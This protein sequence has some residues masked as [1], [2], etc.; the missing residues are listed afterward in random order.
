MP[1][2]CVAYVNG[3]RVGEHSG[4]FTPMEFDLTPALTAGNNRLALFVRDITAAVQG[5]RALHPLGIMQADRIRPVGG[6]Q[7]RVWLES[8]PSVH[9]TDVFVKTST[10]R[11][12]LDVDCELLN[13]SAAPAQLDLR[14]TVQEWRTGRPTT[15]NLPAQQIQLAPGERRTVSVATDWSPAR[16]WSPEH[17]ELHVLG[18][19]LAGEGAGDVYDQRFGFREFWIEGG[20]FVLNGTHAFL[21]FGWKDDWKEIYYSRHAPIYAPGHPVFAGLTS[22]DVRWWNATDGRVADDAFARP[23][24][25]GAIARGNWHPLLGASRRENLSLV[26][27]PVGRGLLMLCPAHIVRQGEHPEARLLLANLQRYLDREDVALAARRV[28][29]A[30]AKIQRPRACS[31]APVSPRGRTVTMQK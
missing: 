19:E 2:D 20:Q 23:A 8:R 14:L 24:A 22:S 18:A 6:I 11:K 9:V 28:S 16:P 4:G 17:P 12:R 7:G 15:A 31:P 26:E 29:V 13:A 3:Q 5:D 21:G 10:R 30:G 27:I 1:Y 25:T